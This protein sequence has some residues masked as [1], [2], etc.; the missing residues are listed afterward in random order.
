MST[1]NKQGQSNPQAQQALQKLIGTK[2]DVSHFTYT[3][4]Q[5]APGIGT[6]YGFKSQGGQN[7]WIDQ[8]G[9]Q[10]Y[11]QQ[12]GGS[13]SAGPLRTTAVPSLNGI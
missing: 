5:Q 6:L 3:G 7:V 10:A 12:S 4:E 8:Q 11:Q 9:Q 1:T 2:G 13:G